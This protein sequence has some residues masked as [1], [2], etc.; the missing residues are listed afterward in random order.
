[1]PRNR[2]L[3]ALFISITYWSD[4]L[5]WRRTDLFLDTLPYKAHTSASDA[6]WAGLPVLTCLGETTARFTRHIEAA[7]TT[8]WERYQRG[9]APKAFAAEPQS[10]PGGAG[11]GQTQPFEREPSGDR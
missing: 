8:T 10:E 7:Y 4:H 1:L 2:R 11:S 3:F 9:E 6:L 5:A